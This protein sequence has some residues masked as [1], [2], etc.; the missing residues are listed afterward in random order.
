MNVYSDVVEVVVNRSIEDVFAWL[1][2]PEHIVQLITFDPVARKED[3]E[4]I[5]LPS[6]SSHS[7][8]GKWFLK[9]SLAMVRRIDTSE[10]EIQQLSALLLHRGT[11]FHYIFRIRY[12]VKR[13]FKWRTLQ[14]GDIEV[15]EYDPPYQFAFIHPGRILTLVSGFN[16]FHRLTLASQQGGTVIRYTQSAEDACAPDLEPRH[17]AELAEQLRTIKELLEHDISS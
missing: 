13:T 2:Q 11:T 5:Y 12:P 9:W 6:H 10:I 8:F 1:A 4:S 14:Y 15:V 7:L 17:K 3:L 16:T